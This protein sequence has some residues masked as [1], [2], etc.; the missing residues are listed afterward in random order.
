M[1]DVW[2]RAELLALGMTTRAITVA[3][4]AGDLI[5]ARRDNYLAADAPNALVEAVRVGG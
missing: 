2:T 1:W 3:V 5:R 4:R